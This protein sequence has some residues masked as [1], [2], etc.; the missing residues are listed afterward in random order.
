MINSRTFWLIVV[1]F[2]IN[3]IPSIKALVPAGDLPYLDLVLAML[4][5]I[6]HINPSQ[7]YSQV[8]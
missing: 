3:G 6:T 4:T 7:D 8:Q 2:L 5:T 1:T